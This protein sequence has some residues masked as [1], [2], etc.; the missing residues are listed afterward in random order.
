MVTF[1]NITIKKRGGGTRLQ[2][3][4]V[5]ASGKFKFVK[6]IKR[7]TSHTRTTKT[8]RKGVRKMPR[9]KRRSN[10][11]KNITQ[12]AFKWIRIGA[13]VAPATA[14]IMQPIANK[15][16]IERIIQDYTGVLISLLS[17]Q[18]MEFRR[19]RVSLEGCSLGY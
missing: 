6:N 19:S 1:K 13:L 3:V 16:K 5:L 17:L 7:K 9:R 11:G 18:L 8:R 12:Q 14:R 10:G 4:K 15:E 2:R